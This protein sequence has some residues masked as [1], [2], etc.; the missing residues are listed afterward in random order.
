MIEYINKVNE[1]GFSTFLICI[2]LAA[3]IVIG[4]KE[5]SGKVLISLGLRTTKS[6]E[7]EKLVQRLDDMQKE[8]EKN[9]NILNEYKISSS[10]QYE[11]W[12]QQSINIRN[13]LEINQSGLKEDIQS[14]TNMFKDF[15]KKED[16]NT[17]A[18][19][20]SSLWRL[21]KDLTTQGF[22]TPDGLKTFM[23]M[24]KAYERAGGDDIYHEK[25]LPE[26]ESL[27]IHYPDGSIYNQK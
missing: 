11:E 16:E 8:I 27:D 13:N 9:K 1:I 12:H 5:I 17:V 21:H 7:K 18:M 19:F 3:L 6:I 15:A 2:V 25:L 20:R 24:G 23:E 14:L 4:I 10:K 22:V 26:V